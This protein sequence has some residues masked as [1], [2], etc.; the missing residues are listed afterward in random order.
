MFH[1]IN[2]WYNIYH[3]C[4]VLLVTGAMTMIA[5]EFQIEIQDIIAA[6]PAQHRQ[7]LLSANSSTVRVLVLAPEQED[8]SEADKVLSPNFLQHLLNNPLQIP[9]FK[10]MKR[11]EIYDRNHF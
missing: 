7:K 11:E 8:V 2:L 10:P 6:S 1:L 4:C 5:I 9:D 3:Y